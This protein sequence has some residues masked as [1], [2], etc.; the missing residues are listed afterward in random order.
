MGF[1]K[2]IEKRFVGK[3]ICV[4][5]AEEAENIIYDQ[6]WIANTGYFRGMAT[7]IDEGILVLDVPDNSEIYINCDSIMAIW[8]PSFSYHRAL[9][10]AF[11]N[12]MF[13]SKKYTNRS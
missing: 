11:T 13:G 2:F 10:T 7:E 9:R 3:E 12:R 4:W 6:S 1:A 8:E 5:L